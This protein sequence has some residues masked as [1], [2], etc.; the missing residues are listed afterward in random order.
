MEPVQPRL[1]TARKV[2]S[3]ASIVF[4]CLA[5]AFLLLKRQL[6]DNP[7]FLSAYKTGCL[8]VL[9]GGTVLTVLSNFLAYPWRDSR[10][11][12]SGAR[13]AY[14]VLDS[15]SSVAVCAMFILL[16]SSPTSPNRG[17]GTHSADR[18]FA[19]MI[20]FAAVNIAAILGS[21]IARVYLVKKQSAAQL[22]SDPR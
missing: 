8:S 15:V 4:L 17:A 16:L 18:E 6:P 2:Y 10:Q 9:V 7:I 21:A 3:S 11:S 1:K 13:I 14:F 5:V 20:A 12:R 22:F 19:F